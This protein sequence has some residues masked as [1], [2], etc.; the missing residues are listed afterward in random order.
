MVKIL[1]FKI[2]THCCAFCWLF[3]YYGLEDKYLLCGSRGL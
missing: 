2:I 3:K 1:G